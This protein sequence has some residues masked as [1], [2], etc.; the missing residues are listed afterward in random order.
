MTRDLAEEMERHLAT[1]FPASVEKGLDYGAIDPVMMDADIF[2]WATRAGAL[3]SDDLDRLSDAKY[4]LCRSIAHL[5]TEARPYFERLIVIADETLGRSLPQAGN[6]PEKVDP[7][8]LPGD[9]R[10]LRGR[11]EADQYA[12]TLA[13]EAPS[14]HLLSG[15][16]V[17]AIAAKKNMK[18][19]VFWLP[20]KQQWALVH[21][22]GRVETDP[23]WPTAML[24]R[25]W[26][27]VIFELSD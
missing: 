9:W 19:V 4:D 11:P 13:E 16:V 7:S 25:H 27:V 17:Q 6:T 2:G 3:S 20:E 24:T 22:T 14:T 10:D 26:S 18:D 8:S 21:L 5:P 15:Q 12:R 1:P 23:R